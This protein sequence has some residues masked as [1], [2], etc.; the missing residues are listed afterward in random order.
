MAFRLIALFIT[1]FL[2]IFAVACS[3]DDD[4]GGSATGSTS[5]SATGNTGAQPPASQPDYCDELDKVEGDVNDLRSEATSLNRSGSETAI[6]NLKTD[7]NQLRAEVRSG[8]DNE[9]VDQAAEDLV[10][11]VDGMETTLRQATQGSVSPIGVIQELE[12]QIPTIVTSL[13]DLR[14]E[15]RCD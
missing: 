5:S 10:Q 7:L 11:A 3:D 12:T 4:N 1:S 9:A 14:E 15:A 13:S 2:L 6:A 8:G